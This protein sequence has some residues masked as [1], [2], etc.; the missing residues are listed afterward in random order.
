MGRFLSPSV[1][2][3]NVD[4]KHGCLV[5]KKWWW[6]KDS[7]PQCVKWMDVSVWKWFIEFICPSCRCTIGWVCQCH[8]A[9][10]P[11]A[12]P[13]PS[14]S[15]SAS[16]TCTSNCMLF[17]WVFC[18]FWK[19]YQRSSA[20]WHYAVNRPKQ[21]VPC[22]QMSLAPNVK[23]KGCSCFVVIGSAPLRPYDDT[24]SAVLFTH[25]CQRKQCTHLSALP[26]LQ[27]QPPKAPHQAP[28]PHSHPLNPVCTYHAEGLGM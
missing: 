26:L 18:C 9:E 5:W 2:V 15:P 10:S 6:G 17:R 20:C 4:L 14:E 12:S 8:A 19:S 28:V 25:C 1:C 11:S 24:S 23:T 21:A 3:W 16:G 13:S 27:S 7:F 22:I